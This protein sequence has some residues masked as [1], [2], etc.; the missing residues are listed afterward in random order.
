M[1]STSPPGEPAGPARGPW[2]LRFCVTA[3]CTRCGAV[4]LDEDSRLTPH[5]DSTGHAREELTRDWGWRLTARPGWA[6]DDEL[7]CPTCGSSS[8]DAGNPSPPT[9]DAGGQ[10]PG[11][12]PWWERPGHPSSELPANA[13]VPPVAG[14]MR[15]EG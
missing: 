2:T 12:A 1:T 4:P 7:L 14:V 11:T 5:F 9:P 10:E 6:D 13:S 15:E 3:A 8:G